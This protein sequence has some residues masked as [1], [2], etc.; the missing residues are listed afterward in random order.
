MTG[1]T[2]NK[3]LGKWHF[4][5]MFIFFNLTFFP[6]F[7]VGLLGQPRRVFEY[8]QNL[9]V[10]NDFS[11]VSAFLLGASF[12]IFIANFVWSIFIDP[13][14]SPANPWNSL[15]LEWQTPVPLPAYNFAR[16]PVVLADPYHYGRGDSQPVA[17]LGPRT[18]V[19]SGAVPRDPSIVPG[20]D[21]GSGH[22]GATDAR[23]PIS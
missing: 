1:K 18:L 8:A 12:L 10:L 14:P 17:D 15:G 6:L 23:P 4:W 5:T 20:P 7:L 9:Q 21:V 3:R 13:K 22:E 19:L 16:I 11:S 2:M